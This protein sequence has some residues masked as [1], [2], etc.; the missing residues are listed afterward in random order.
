MSARS[1]AA[2]DLARARA[3]P[4]GTAVTV[5][6]DDY[7]TADGTRIRDYR[8]S[9]DGAVLVIAVRPSSVLTTGGPRSAP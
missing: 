7:A 6:G 9:C 3:A 2:F 4:N 8:P 5:Y 1:G